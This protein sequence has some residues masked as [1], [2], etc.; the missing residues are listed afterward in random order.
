MAFVEGSGR[1]SG[2]SVTSGGPLGSREGPSVRESHLAARGERS[3][4][5]PPRAPLSAVVVLS[6]VATLAGCS[7]N[8]GSKRDAGREPDGSGGPF[9]AASTDEWDSQPSDSGPAV[10]GSNGCPNAEPAVMF[11]EKAAGTPD[12]TQNDP[13]YGGFVD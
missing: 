9:D 1:D 2:C 12:Y 13:S 10:D 4:Q 6:V 8:D 5:S 3:T 11:T 7:S